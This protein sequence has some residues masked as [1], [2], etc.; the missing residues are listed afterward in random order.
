MAGATCPYPRATAYIRGM[1]EGATRRQLLGFDDGVNRV[2]LFPG[3]PYGPPALAVELIVNQLARKIGAPVPDAGVVDVPAAL[4]E[5]REG[6]HDLG[7]GLCFGARFYEQ[8]INLADMNLPKL[9]S[10]VPDVG[11]LAGVVVLDTWCWNVDRS[12]NPANLLVVSDDGRLRILAIDHEQCLGGS[13]WLSLWETLRRWLWGD[14]AI[15]H[16]AF[17]PYLTPTNFSPYLNRLR[18]LEAHD[19]ESVVSA[20]PHE[21]RITGRRKRKWLGELVRRKTLTADL[22][23]RRFFK[24]LQAVT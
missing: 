2:V 7:A 12:A 17:V 15:Y 19:I 1:G 21:W 6:L 22:I 23:E 3:N 4:L 8:A 24:G 20:V 18:D 5:G 13:G 9:L 11:A 10:L 16:E 14:Q